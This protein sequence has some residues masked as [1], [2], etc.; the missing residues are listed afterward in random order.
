MPLQTLLPQ[1][2]VLWRIEDDLMLFQG[3]GRTGCCGSAAPSSRHIR[4]D[5]RAF[6]GNATDE[7]GLVRGVSNRAQGE[8]AVAAHD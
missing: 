5:R 6:A 7:Q 2:Q 4:A 3:A 1:V 8:R